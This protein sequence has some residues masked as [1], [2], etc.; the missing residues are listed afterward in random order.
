MVSCHV[1]TRLKNFRVVVMQRYLKSI[2]KP[3]RGQSLFISPF[4]AQPYGGK[5]GQVI[6]MIKEDVLIRFTEG[7]FERF[8]KSLLFELVEEK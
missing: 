4:L 3:R 1:Y 6:G 2:E 7:H 8:A 5:E